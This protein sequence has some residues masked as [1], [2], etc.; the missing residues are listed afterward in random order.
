MDL[1]PV[2]IKTPQRW[3]VPFGQAMEEANVEYVLS[4]PPF[5]QIDATKFPAALP[6]RGILQ[7][8]ARLVPY[9]DGD[10]IV[11][12]GD[13]GNSAFFIISGAV[14]VELDQLPESMLGRQKTRAKAFSVR[15]LSCGRTIASPKSATRRAITPIPACPGAA[16]RMRSTSIFRTCPP[17]STNIEPP[18]WP[19][20][21]CLGSWLPWDARRARPRFSRTATL[22]C[23]KSAGR[24]CA[25]SCAAMR[26]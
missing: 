18:G 16:V 17:S 11:R 10:L 26:R 21:R 24:G 8:D 2:G 15:W 9:Q 13:Y 20:A 25:T 23:W 12:R 19:R 6:L 5:N 22:S 7:N 4:V 1:D 3:D 14:R